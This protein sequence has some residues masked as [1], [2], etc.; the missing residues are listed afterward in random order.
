MASDI[1]TFI[2]R[3]REL[4]GQAEKLFYVAA[5]DIPPVKRVEDLPQVLMQ[6]F[7][8]LKVNALRLT[9]DI[10]TSGQSFDEVSANEI[11]EAID[12]VWERALEFDS[13][14]HQVIKGYQL[15]VIKGGKP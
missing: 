10:Q 5:E 4:K 8:E 1:D 3:A 9:L 14:C 7:N 13:L 15:K 6:E 2:K 12:V 11:A